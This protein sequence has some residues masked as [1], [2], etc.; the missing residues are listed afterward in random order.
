MKKY[1]IFI[2]LIFAFP[3]L[4]KNLNYLLDIKYKDFPEKK[5]VR[6]VC[7]FTA[8]P[9]FEEI[10]K[11]DSNI[12]QILLNNTDKKN[13]IGNLKI[14]STIIDEI[15]TTQIKSSV[16][17][18]IKFKT[19]IK[20]YTSIKS[21]KPPLL[22]LKVYV[23]DVIKNEPEKKILTKDNVTE[24]KTAKVK[25]ESKVKNKKIDNKTI[26]K[27]KK[28]KKRFDNTTKV[29]KAEKSKITV[30]PKIKAVITQAQIDRARNIYEQGLALMAEKKF[31]EAIEIFN[32]LI[33]STKKSNIYNIKAQFRLLD[34]YYFSVNK[35][36]AREYFDILNSYQSLISKY[37]KID[38]AGWAAFQIANCYK[39]LGF[40]EEALG[41]YR[42]V[43]KYFPKS[44]YSIKSNIEVADIYYKLKKYKQ[45]LKVFRDFL[46]KYPKSILSIK[47]NYYIGNCLY[48]LN[49]FKEANRVYK[50]ALKKNSDYAN[51]DP[52]I[53]YNIGNSYF[54]I[55]KYTKAR[56]FFL[57]VRNLFPKSTYFDI[58]LLKIGETYVKEKDYKSALYVFKRVVDV[59]KNKENI[60]IAR[61]EMADIGLKNKI[62]EKALIAKYGQFIDPETAFKYIIE[63]FKYDK[64][65]QIAFSRL[66]NYLLKKKNYKDAVL[67][68][69]EFFKRFPDSKIKRNMDKKMYPA[70]YGY[71]DNLF[72]HENYKKIVYYY[73]KYKKSYLKNERPLSVFK[74]IYYSYKNLY[75]FDYAKNLLNRLKY[76]YKKDEDL[77]FE[78]IFMD[79]TFSSYEDALRKTE[80]FYK[81]FPDSK[82]NQKVKFFEG[83]AYKQIGAYEKA[84]NV[85]YEILEKDVD[86]KGEVL[87]NIADTYKDSGDYKNAEKIYNTLIN[88]Y[89]EQT[90]PK[91]MLKNAYFN[92]GYMKYL[93]KNYNDAVKAFN[94]FKNLYPGSND[95]DEANYYILNSFY[96]LGKYREALKFFKRIKNSFKNENFKKLSNKLIDDINWEKSFK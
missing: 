15:N 16:L 72:K 82:Y 94:D 12:L 67:F 28:I 17:V 81:E 48:H 93:L 20:S 86:N 4:A 32:S 71:I 65:T 91:Y 21:N 75:L 83:V 25:V 62:R 70:L 45:A 59:S 84:L 26:E 6:I 27:L 46:Q 74:K 89:N 56:E 1:L 76:M 66:V 52:D 87:Y 55:G 43:V 23:T 29:K 53:L 50:E 54:K 88:N 13:F 60:I 37:P 79:I 14:P 8:P 78:E 30:K 7:Y 63:H 18:K 40:Y 34:C 47:A 49:K 10:K 3:L 58:A 96:K 68:L 22:Y 77:K 69:E 61:L 44:I 5:F 95:I 73:E 19:D 31:N 36:N 57:K 85:F 24:E 39:N 64:L 35:K 51:T 38:E 92:L 2:I 9:L 42:Y 11:K 80:K 33:S 90:I 41:G